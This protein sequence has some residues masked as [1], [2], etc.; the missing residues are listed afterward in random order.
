MSASGSAGDC[1][2]DPREQMLGVEQAIA[3]LLRHARAPRTSEHTGLADAGGRVLARDV[4]AAADIPG[5][6]NSA[7]DGY[8]LR[9]SDIE[10]ARSAGLALVQ[11]IAAGQVGVP[12]AD[13]C[14]ARIFTGAPIPEGADTVAMQEHCRLENDRLIIERELAPG[15]NVRPRGGDI[16]AG[17]TLLQAGSVL[18]AAQIGLAA[19][20]GV[21][22]VDVWPR[23]RVAVF[24]T[25]DELV[26]PGRPLQAGQIYNSNRFQLTELLHSQGCTV[27]DL[28]I[29]SDDLAATRELL[30]E[31][32]RQA[33]L[34]ITTGGVSVGEEDHVKAALRSVGELTLWRIR[35]KPGKPLAFGSIDTTPFIGLP[36]N[37]VSAFVTF[38]LF[39]RPFLHTMQGRTSVVPQSFPVR[40]GFT[41]TAR[42]RREY[43]GVRL[44]QDPES[45]PVAEAFPR[46]GSSVLSMLVWSE[47]LVEIPEGATVRDNDTVHFLPFTSLMS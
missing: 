17:S 44:R 45:G 23:L 38:L 39:A 21:T 29:A 1:C 46:Q 47:G 4:G 26:E 24:S 5:F 6:D 28:G 22:G 25:G 12:L 13:G 20:A 8:A 33:D 42:H 40:A 7:M 16:T 36:G 30:L 9:G 34:V 32:A 11:R 18:G 43:L 37:P 15:A 3:E 10:T 19:A 31:G 35:M 14:A 2:A 27:I 41:H